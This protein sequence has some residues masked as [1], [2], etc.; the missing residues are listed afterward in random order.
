VEV[1]VGEDVGFVDEAGVGVAEVLGLVLLLRVARYAPTP[2]TITAM[3][4][5]TTIII[6]LIPRTLFYLLFFFR[7]FL[8]PVLYCLVFSA[9]SIKVF[10]V[11]RKPRVALTT[12]G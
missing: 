1:E 12:S 11:L 10:A 4:I 7:P 5:M 9:A 6:A 8:F 2:T 3:T